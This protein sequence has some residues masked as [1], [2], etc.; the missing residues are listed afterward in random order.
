VLC[1]HF[2]HLG[3]RLNALDIRAMSAVAHPRRVTAARSPVRTCTGT[4]RQVNRS[5]CDGT[6][7]AEDQIAI[8]LLN[9]RSAVSV[10]Q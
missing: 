8:T 1:P 2:E 4:R 3:V 6:A 10:I 7:C 9:S 5:I